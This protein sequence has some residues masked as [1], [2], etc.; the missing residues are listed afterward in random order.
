M[1]DLVHDHILQRG[2]ALR[3]LV[4]WKVWVIAYHECVAIAAGLL[5]KERRAELERPTWEAVK[6][7]PEFIQSEPQGTPGISF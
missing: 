3:A 2:A 6:K 1:R 4:R 5:G 7:A